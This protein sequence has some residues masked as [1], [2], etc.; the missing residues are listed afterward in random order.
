MTTTVHT[1]TNVHTGELLLA[2]QQH[3][4]LQFVLENLRL[5]VL[6]G[7]TVHPQQAIAARAVS[8]GGGGFL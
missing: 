6:D 2:Q 5:D 4:L 3:G 8:N 7:A 1:D